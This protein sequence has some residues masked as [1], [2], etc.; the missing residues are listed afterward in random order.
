MPH[1]HHAFLFLPQARAA[2][3]RIATFLT[4]PDPP[5][6][7]EIIDVSASCAIKPLSSAEFVGL[8]R[9]VGEPK[10]GGEDEDEGEKEREVVLEGV[11]SKL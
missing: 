9:K 8:L 4:S 3:E 1:V 7:P 2:I 10:V 11:R 6:S 5:K